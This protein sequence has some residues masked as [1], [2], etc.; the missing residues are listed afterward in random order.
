VTKSIKIDD[1]ALQRLDQARQPEESYSSV[2][3]RYVPQRRSVDEILKALR[4]GPG[5]AALE[6][7]DES[8]QRRRSRLRKPR[9]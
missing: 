2:I 7:A 6:A 1:D 5:K 9:T 8:V 4:S 3:C